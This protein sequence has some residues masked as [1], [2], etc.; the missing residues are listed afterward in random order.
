MNLI[1]LDNPSIFWSLSHCNFQDKDPS[2]RLGAGLDGYAA[3]KFHPFSKG[4]DSEKL[5][6]STPPKLAPESDVLLEI[7]LKF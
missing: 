3:L 2:K 6:E 7:C 4:I 5:R 1:L